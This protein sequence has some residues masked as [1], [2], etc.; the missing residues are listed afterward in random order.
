MIACAH[1]P[2]CSFAYIFH[3]NGHSKWYLVE[4]RDKEINNYSNSND[5]R[6]FAEA[7]R[8][9]AW[10]IKRDK[11]TWATTNTRTIHVTKDKGSINTIINYAARFERRRQQH[12][13][14][15]FL[16]RQRFAEGL[17]RR[18]DYRCYLCSM[19]LQCKNFAVANYYY[20][21]NEW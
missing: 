3:C 12:K 17:T 19:R 14:L 5:I 2:D 10:P 20:Q 6:V 4:R 16:Q 13:K 21:L 1:T 11:H 9:F 18:I 7:F 15:N 8:V